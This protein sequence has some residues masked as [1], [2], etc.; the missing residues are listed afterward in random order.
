F[1]EQIDH[2][3]QVTPFFHVHLKKISHV[4]ERRASLAKLSLLLYRCRLCVALRDY[5]AAQGVAKFSGHFLISWMAVVIAESY[6][7][8]GVCRF[9]KYSPAIVRHLHVIEMRPAL[10]L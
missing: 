4:V 7:R 6:A 2:S 10:W 5:D 9:Q 8:F 1:L 3:P